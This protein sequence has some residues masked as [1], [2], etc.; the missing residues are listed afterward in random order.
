MTNS[1]SACIG[2]PGELR[3]MLGDLESALIM[4]GYDVALVYDQN[5][6]VIEVANKNSYSTRLIRLE[7][8]PEAYQGDY[9]DILFDIIK[10]IRET[11]N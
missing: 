11:E 10:A 5:D 8:Y 3:E 4:A 2:A 6:H 7:G 1:F 9:R